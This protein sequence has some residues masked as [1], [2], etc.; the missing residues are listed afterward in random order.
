MAVYAYQ[1]AFSFY[2]FDLASAAS[3]VILVLTG[4]V[5]VYYIR[6]QFKGTQQ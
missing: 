4:L 2:R 5:C 6:A 3:G 1:Q